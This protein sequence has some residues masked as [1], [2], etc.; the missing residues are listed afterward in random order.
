VAHEL[1]H[2]DHGGVPGYE[3]EAQVVG[4]QMWAGFNAAPRRTDGAYDAMYRNYL[5]D[6][7]LFITFN[8]K[9]AWKG[10]C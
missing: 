3:D 5:S 2:L 4:F 1:V 6:P 9:T 8:C 10:D 7:G